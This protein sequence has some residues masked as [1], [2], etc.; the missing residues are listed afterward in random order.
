ML[1]TLATGAV[2]LA[3]LATTS[4]PAHAGFKTLPNDKMSST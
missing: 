4:A 3:S 1:K 2:L